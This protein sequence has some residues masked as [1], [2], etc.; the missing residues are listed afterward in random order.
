[1]KFSFNDYLGSEN[2]EREYKEFTF[3]L[4]GLNIDKQ[5]AD[6]YCYTNKFEFNEAVIKN[7]K[8][9][10]KIYLNINACSSFNSNING[11]FYIGVNDDG[12]IKGIPYKGNLPI[13]DI[14]Q[15]IYKILT[16]NLSNPFLYNIDFHKY[17]K[18]KII[19][20]NQ[21]QQPDDYV[22]P[23][24]IKYLKR[25]IKL[26]E[27]LD[28]YYEE[29]KDWRIRFDFVNQKLFKIINN[30]ESRIILID[31]IKSNN[32][33]SPV[34]DLL[35][36]DYKEIYQPHENVMYLKEDINSP[37]FW[38][39]RWKDTTIRKLR[40][41]KPCIIESLPNVSINL[42]MNIS[43][44]IPF[45]I[46]NNNDMNLYIIQIEFKTLDF[47]VKFEN[48]NLFSYYDVIKKKW[49][50]YHRII[51]NGGPSCFPI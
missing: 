27:K 34:I 36:T 7:I 11:C 22:H 8:R 46:H 18:I 13:K 2:L 32:P 51:F 50:K 12:F 26:K 5:T 17:V 42:I 23:D 25:K 41:E 29:M 48:D 15:Y 19:K 38:V 14:E 28:K 33:D 16:E 20:I 6:E 31:Y 40:K 37:Y 30:I 9:Y 21:P 39:T 47:G 24:Y 44:M 10:I 49:L 4:A 45:W 35:N 1:M 3:N 43:E